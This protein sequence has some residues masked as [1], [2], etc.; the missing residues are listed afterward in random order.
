[1]EFVADS[2]T[3]F[4]VRLVDRGGLESRGGMHFQ[5]DVRGDEPRYREWLTPVYG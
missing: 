3:G 2:S 5:L 1:M 4:D